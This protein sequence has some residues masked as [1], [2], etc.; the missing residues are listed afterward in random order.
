VDRSA[1]ASEGQARWLR[2]AA[3]TVTAL[4][5]AGVGSMLLRGRSVDVLYARWMLHNGPVAVG[6]AWLGAMVLQRRPRHRS[7]ALLLLLGAASALHVASISLADARLVAAGIAE[8][9]SE[10]VPFAPSDLPLDAAVPMWASGW[11][12]LLACIPAVTL[13]LLVFPDG[14]LPSRRWRIAVALGGAATAVMVVAYAI[15]GWPGSDR[16]IQMRG[17]VEVHPTA[18]VLAGVG[19]VLVVLGAGASVASLVVRWRAADAELRARI[20]P[21]LLASVAMVL[22]LV[23]TFPWQ[24]LWVPAGMVSLWA[25]LI[26]YAVSVSRY[27]L[28][29]LDVVVDRAVVAT[30]LAAGATGLYLAVVVAAGSVAGRAQDSTVVPLLAAAV[31][32]VAFEPARRRTRRLVDRLLYG[33][34]RDAAEVLAELADRLPRTSPDVLLGEVVDLLVRSTGASGAEIVIDSP[35]EASLTSLAGASG[36][37]GA[38]LVE[39]P[40]R[41]DGEVLGTLRLRGRARSDLVVDAEQL[42]EGVAGTLGVVLHNA[43]LTAE[44]EAQVEQLRGSRLRL[45]RAQDEARR[46]LERDIHDG[47]QAR[48]ISLRIR[49]GLATSLAA[50]S[51][52]PRL[53]ALLEELGAELDGAVR[54]LRA[55]GHGL[56]PPVLEGAGIAAALRAEARSLPLAVTVREDGFGRY[57]PEVE[58]A[59]YFSCLEAIQNATKHGAGREVVVELDHEGP[60]L[61]FTVTDDGVGFDP[62]AARRG[63][64]L[65]NLRDRIGSLGGEVAVRSGIGTG[66]VVRGRVP[67]EPVVGA[68]G[69]PLAAER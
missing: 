62:Q 50:E 46:A 61:A 37:A 38:V 53:V 49:L 32:A 55:L 28:H 65:T 66:T 15:E 10:F 69:Q 33:R 57:R 23:A 45:V 17:Q 52:E 34:D 1:G 11:L 2:I 63:A 3:W 41:H 4:V 40:V 25:F 19:G 22:V 5:V 58:A 6:C 36:G 67:A 44:L 68:D 54:A 18:L 9:G 31:V 43:V 29:D 60:A 64:G 35:G 21:L 39:V 42:V 8:Q 16:E 7:G 14:E 30:L 26:T 24:P 48:L 59:V 56:H 20:R 47:A 51:D 12:W 13:L 27:R